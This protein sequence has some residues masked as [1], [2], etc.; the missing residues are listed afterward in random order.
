MIDTA[1]AV[2]RRKLWFDNVDELRAELERV[3]AADKAGRLKSLGNWT[4]GQILSH[5]AAW[6]EYADAGFPVPRPPWIIRCFLRWRLPAM[7]KHGMPVGVK[8]PRV[9]GGT[10]GADACTT[11]EGLARYQKALDR[12]TNGIPPKHESPAFG[13]LTFEQAVALNL[14]HAELHLGF[15]TF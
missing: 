10:T 9:P 8:I 11:A 1:K 15:L 7:L 4:P 14:R 2:G 3:E 12:L 6:I 13:K 5:L